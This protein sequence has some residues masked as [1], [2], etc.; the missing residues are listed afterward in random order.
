MTAQASDSIT[1][2]NK[3]TGMRTEPLSE[4]IPKLNIPHRFVAP[5]SYCW[6]GYFAEWAV[7]NN[8]LLLTGFN[9]FILNYQKVGMEYIFPGENIV[10][11]HWFSG[12]IQIPMGEMICYIHGGYASINEGD[13]CLIFENGLLIKEFEKWLTAEEIERYKNEESNGLDDF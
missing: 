7:E 4:Y 12:E 8:K 10:F 2:R 3:T 9:G 1:Y 6:R 11:A 13:R 5:A